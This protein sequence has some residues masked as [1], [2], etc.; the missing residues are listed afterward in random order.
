MAVSEDAD[1]GSSTQPS[2][3]WLCDPVLPSSTVTRLCA[4]C[5]RVNGIVEVVV[6]RGNSLELHTVD[7]GRNGTGRGNMQV[8]CRQPA[9]AVL[10]DMRTLD[11]CS[12]SQV[13]LGDMATHVLMIAFLVRCSNQLN[14]L[15]SSAFTG[16]AR[17]AGPAV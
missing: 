10:L 15:V 6:A 17:Q 2:G 12:Q 4:G 8:L 9:D 16:C 13:A 1:P 14:V 11:G 5:F 3:T 7:T